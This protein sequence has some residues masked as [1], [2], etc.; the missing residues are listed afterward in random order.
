M[1]ATTITIFQL[2]SI[3]PLTSGVKLTKR[4]NNK[5]KVFV[6]PKKH[7]QGGNALF[8]IRCIKVFR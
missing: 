8:I 5:E 7:K 2:H 3:R 6:I 4:T 1:R